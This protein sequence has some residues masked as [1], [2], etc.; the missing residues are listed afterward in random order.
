ML[1]KLVYYR[2]DSNTV[3]WFSNYLSGHMQ[4]VEVR[5]ED[6]SSAL[7]GA[8]NVSRGF[9]QGSIL[10]PVL[11]ILYTADIVDSVRNCKCHLYAEVLQMYV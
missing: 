10:G 1:S 7:S 5:C 9:P 4:R 6:G 11:F 8:A 2:F 3:K